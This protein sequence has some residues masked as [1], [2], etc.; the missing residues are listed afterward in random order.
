MGG[1]PPGDGPHDPCGARPPQGMQANGTA[2]GP[3]TRTPAPT[4]RVDDGPRQ[5]AQ[6][7]TVGGGGAPDRRRPSQRTRGPRNPGCPPLRN[8]GNTGHGDSAGPRARTPVPTAGGQRAPTAPRRRA[9]GGGRAPGLGRPSQWDRHGPRGGEH[10]VPTRT[11]ECRHAEPAYELPQQRP[12]A[13]TARAPG[14]G[15]PHP[16]PCS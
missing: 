2:P 8:P 5:P 11:H 3:H 7:A 12:A 15:N 14:T 6:R 9:A 13:P 16:T 4:A 10:L 1:H